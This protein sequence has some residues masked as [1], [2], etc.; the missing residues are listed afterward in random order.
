MLFLHLH[1]D[2]IGRSSLAQAKEK[3]NRGNNRCYKIIDHLPPE[4]RLCI[5]REQ[6][7]VQTRDK[8]SL[9][10]EIICFY[11]EISTQAI[12]LNRAAF[13]VD[14]SVSSQGISAIQ[15]TKNKKG[16]WLDSFLTKQAV[17][18]QHR[19]EKL[20]VVYRVKHSCTAN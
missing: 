7:K 17:G 9:I 2:C 16:P 18:S 12:Q 1:H 5:K 6:K 20:F 11:S 19:S 15:I 8:G 4:V 10:V 14:R 13:R 3:N